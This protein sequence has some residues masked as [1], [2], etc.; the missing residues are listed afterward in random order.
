MTRLVGMAA[1]LGVTKVRVTGGEPLTR[2][3]V[4][5]FFRQLSLIESIR[6]IGISTNGTL[7]AKTVDPGRTVAE[8]LAQLRVKNLNV[9]LD[10]LDRETY[11]MITGRDALPQTLAG[12]EPGKPSVLTQIPLNR[13][14]LPLHTHRLLQ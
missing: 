2:R 12:L 14:L 6:D 9:S 10:T 13:H 3:N 8:S 11:A 1:S 4:L 7:L 5:E